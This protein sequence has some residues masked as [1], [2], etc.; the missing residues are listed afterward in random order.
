MAMSNSK[1]I[2]KSI[3]VIVIVALIAIAAVA[4]GI[5]AIQG[6]PRTVTVTQTQTVTTT[7][8]AQQKVYTLKLLHY[9]LPT[10][11]GFETI[12][13]FASMTENASGGRIKIELYTTDELGIAITE[14]LDATA[15]GVVDLAGF[16]PGYLAAQDPMFAL[17]GG[18][19][20]PISDV[21]E[22]IWET[23]EVE[24]LINATLAKW[25]VVY[26][27]PLSACPAEPLLLRKPITSLDDLKGMIL[28]S[29]GL[30]AEFYSKLGAQVVMIPGGELYTAI[31]LG[32][33]D[34]FEYLDLE[35]VYRMGFADVVKYLILPTR[36]YNLHASA[37]LDMFL[38]AN[39]KV[40][41]ELPED[42]K[43]II[44]ST[45]YAALIQGGIHVFTLNS[46]AKEKWIAAGATIIELPQKDL[47]KIVQVATEI[48]AE[49]AKKSP[50]ALEYV[51]RLVKAW[52][53]MGYEDW[54]SALE[55]A[56]A[57]SK[58]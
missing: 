29:T 24:D 30:G 20:G 12:K 13:L 52:R 17:A 22:I 11:P 55:E 19:P 57:S 50:D 1:P 32:T 48:Y 9:Y 44:K 15:R 25:G 45:L 5:S 53:D 36:G 34:A 56:L 28:R 43:E 3:F 8:P 16:Y 6:A 47:A 14:I 46:E 31:Q 40:W 41:Q 51:T 58:P 54:A 27:G 21:F 4:V 26:V 37:G 33:I 7:A 10:D 35:G 39:P 49:Y 2:S 18:G 42:L 23:K 38:I